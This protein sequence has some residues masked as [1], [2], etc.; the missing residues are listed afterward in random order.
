MLEPKPERIN[1][2]EDTLKRFQ[3]VITGL[4]ENEYQPV[5]REIRNRL[6]DFKR[7]TESMPPQDND[8]NRVWIF[9][10]KVEQGLGQIEE[11]LSSAH[12]SIYPPGILEKLKNDLRDEFEEKPHLSNPQYNPMVNSQTMLSAT[13][14]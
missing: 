12:A 8:P 6:G 3:G 9:Y 14:D 4:D 1:I 10:K 2:A 7:F 11:W 5:L 13:D